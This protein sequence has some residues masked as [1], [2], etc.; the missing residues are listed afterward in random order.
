M[1]NLKELAGEIA[2]TTNASIAPA[3]DQYKSPKATPRVG[4]FNHTHV[5]KIARV[6]NEI[7]TTTVGSEKP[8]RIKA[9]KKTSGYV[10]ME[11]GTFAAEVMERKIRD[12]R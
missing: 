1:L 11:M 12:A 8:P 3:N 7:M 9:I 10:Q 4:R 2:M 6:S 5:V